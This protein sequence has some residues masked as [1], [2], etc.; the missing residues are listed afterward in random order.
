[1]RSDFSKSGPE[2]SSGEFPTLGSGLRLS[3]EVHAWLDGRLPAHA[4]RKGDA[5]HDVEFWNR[6]ESDIAKRRQVRT[7]VHVQRAVMAALPGASRVTVRPWH[8][9][10]VTV[11]RGVLALGGAALVALG[12]ALGIALG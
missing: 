8:L 11:A 10:T 6:I 2:F 3:P 4:A 7:P 12:L 5:A 9:R 1:M